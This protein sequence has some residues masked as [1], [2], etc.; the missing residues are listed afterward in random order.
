MEQ[1][2]KLDSSKVFYRFD[3]DTPPAAHARPDDLVEFECLDA[4]GGQIVSEE[5][6][7]ASIDWNRVNPATG[8]LYVEGASPGDALTVKI[9]SI[10]LGEWGVIVTVPGEGVLPHLAKEAR[11]RIYRVRSDTVEFMGF[12]LKARKMI[13]VIGVASSERAPTGT[14]GRHGGNLD[15]RLISEGS[16]VYLPVEYPGGLL[17]VGDL[18]AAMGDGEVCVAACEVGGRVLARVNVVKGLAP[19]W[20][21]VETKDASYLLISAE[22][23]EN[24]LKLA[25]EEAV[26]LLSRAFRLD[27]YDAYML[28]SIALDFEISQ[29]VDPRK[30]IRVRLPKE[31][32]STRRLLEN[33]TRESGR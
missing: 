25:V 2:V 6:T 12:K 26:G 11:T 23:L 27:W 31:L 17:G 18:H 21:V 4:L 8:P 30:T 15:T 19:K 10:E 3:P 24:A 32:I 20:P 5:Q 9:L 22:G 7:V 33:F 1:L 29:V 14:P 16:I 28:A 13:G